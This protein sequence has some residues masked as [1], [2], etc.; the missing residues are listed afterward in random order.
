MNKPKEIEYEFDGNSTSYVYWEQY[1]KALE[2]Y[3]KYLESKNRS[4]KT[5]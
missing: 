1:A 2:E 3:I 4:V 5:D